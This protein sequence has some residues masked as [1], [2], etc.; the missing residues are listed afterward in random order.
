MG[1]LS[2]QSEC[3]L[4]P[5]LQA[6]HKHTS[7]QLNEG[8]FQCKNTYKRIN[9]HTHTH[10]GAIFYIPQWCFCYRL[11]TNKT[12]ERVDTS[13]MTGIQEWEPREVQQH[14]LF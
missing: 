9:T 14:S 10:T 11:H 8:G 4:G 13:A 1:A 7:P 6:H 3:T 5:G 12:A 2:M